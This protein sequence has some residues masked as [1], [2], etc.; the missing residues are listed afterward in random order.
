[1]CD[2]TGKKTPGGAG[3]HTGSYRYST[4]LRLHGDVGVHRQHFHNCKNLW[5]GGPRLSWPYLADELAG[6]RE[7]TA[8]FGV[9]RRRVDAAAHHRSASVVANHDVGH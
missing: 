1:M 3:T 4:Q 8:P 2:H 9:F 6:E 7:R 5:Q